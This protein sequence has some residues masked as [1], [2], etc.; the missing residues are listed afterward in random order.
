MHRVS[1]RRLRRTGDDAGFSLIELVMTVA[2]IGVITVA[3]TGVII[4]FLR[5]TAATQAR[6]TESHDVQFAAAYW[7]RDVASIGVRKTQPDPVSGDFPTAKWASATACGNT[8]AGYT[9][10]ITVVW[11]E[12]TS[13]VSTDAPTE[14]SVTYAWSRLGPTRYDLVRVRCGTAPSVVKVADNLDA[15][16][17]VKC[18]GAVAGCAPTST[19]PRI[20]TMELSVHDSSERHTG[21][22][23]ATLT[24]ER[25]QS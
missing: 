5:N 12:Y 23:T 2:I 6:L 3:L 25:R 19:V 14:I 20:I 21:S 11:G 4:V 17:V 9:P 7:Q 15:E 10:A 13:L 8:P 24:G 1:V 22:Y 16:P 18:D